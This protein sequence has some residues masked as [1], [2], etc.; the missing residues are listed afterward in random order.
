MINGE[1]VVLVTVH[2]AH[3]FLCPMAYDNTQVPMIAVNMHFHRVDHK[4]DIVSSERTLPNLSSPSGETSLEGEMELEPP[5][6]CC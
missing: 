5:V 4:P 2:L 1:C 3:A 6:S